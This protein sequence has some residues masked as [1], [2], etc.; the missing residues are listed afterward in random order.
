MG[1]NRSTRTSL[2]GWSPSSARLGPPSGARSPRRERR[3]RPE[4]R[5]LM[6]FPLVAAAAILVSAA[7]AVRGQSGDGTIDRA[8][9]G[10]AKIKSVRGTFEQTVTNQLTSSSA[11]AR[12]EYAQDRPN[13][14]SIRFTQ[15]AADAIVS[16][17]KT[18]WVY[19]PS[20]APGQVI[21]R[22]ATD[23][24]QTPIDL[25]GAFLDSP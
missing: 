11:T 18:V 3:R 4:C 13:L 24:T 5:T 23:R 1:R 25:T 21:K 2:R 15:P 7:P 14:L 17:G 12:G 6:R 19:L 8:V 10:W 16:D 20:T 22:S 9:Q